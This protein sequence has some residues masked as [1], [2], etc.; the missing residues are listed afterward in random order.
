MGGERV[1]G[2]H[3]VSAKKGVEEGVTIEEG[4]TIEE[5]VTIEY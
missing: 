1:K 4:M 3:F 5:G 2:V